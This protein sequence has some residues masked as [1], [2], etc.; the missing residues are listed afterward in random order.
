MLLFVPFGGFAQQYATNSNSLS[1]IH[2]I[3][4][5]IAYPHDIAFDGENLWI[6]GFGDYMIFKISPADGKVLKTIPTSHQKPFGLT[7]DGSSLWVANATSSLI[8]KVDT[9]N[10]A[11]LATISAPSS[12]YSAGLAFDGTNL[13]KNDQ[14]GNMITAVGD[15]TFSFSQSGSLMNKYAAIGNFPGGL[16]YD[17]THL[18]STDNDLDKIHKIEPSTYSII[19]TYDAPGEMCL[20]LAFDGK[21]LWVADNK[22][23]S[24]F[25]VDI[26]FASSVKCDLLTPKIR[27]HPNPASQFLNITLPIEQEIIEV[28]I[29]DLTGKIVS[30]THGENQYQLKIPLKAEL[31]GIYIIR[32]RMGNETYTE[33]IIIN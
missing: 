27:I 21:Y 28:T 12:P 31:R 20:G 22:T 14:R 33:K 4:S 17:G 18:W 9:L 19:E 15:S 26:G 16:T 23:D 6:A 32:V 2:S 5:P 29:T 30:H 1:I 7:F 24:I 3:P 13:W 11:V 10:G 8:Q 25:Q